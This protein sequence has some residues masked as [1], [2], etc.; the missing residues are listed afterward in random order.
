MAY[1]GLGAEMPIRQRD[2]ATEALQQDLARLG[3]LPA[4]GVD[5]VWGQNT[6]R[7]LETAARQVGWAAAPYT[8]PEAATL[9]SGTATVPDRL[10]TLLH[11]MQ[12]APSTDVNDPVA[13]EPGGT[14]I[15]PHLTAE[16]PPPKQGFNWMP[17]ALAA[18][19]AVAIGGILFVALKKR[20]RR[21]AVA[22]NRRRRRRQRR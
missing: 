10:L 15:G 17:V 3:F 7:A 6:A 22:A 13:P 14:T 18:G 1:Y 16:D 21:V 8:P 11:N 4:S 19:G 20:N 2:A 9:R 5:G 12:A